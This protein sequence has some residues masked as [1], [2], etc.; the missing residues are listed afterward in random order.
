MVILHGFSTNWATS[1]AF[2]CA[3][4]IKWIFCLFFNIP[5]VA[6]PEL[7][8]SLVKAIA[9]SMLGSKENIDADCQNY[10]KTRNMVIF[11]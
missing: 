7:V 2:N 8:D 10:L 11:L 6:F 9:D 5:L 3:F 1:Y 4:Y